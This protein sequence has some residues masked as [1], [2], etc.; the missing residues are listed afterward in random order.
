MATS[1]PATTNG[2]AC[3]AVNGFD[4]TMPMTLVI[5]K[6]ESGANDRTLERNGTST[7]AIY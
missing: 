2:Y 4:K 1:T 5:E 7:N 6:S 3:E